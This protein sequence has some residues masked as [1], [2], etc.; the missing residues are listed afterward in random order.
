VITVFALLL[1]NI[2]EIFSFHKIL[3]ILIKTIVLIAMAV[4]FQLQ[5]QTLKSTSNMG[6]SSTRSKKISFKDETDQSLL[7]ESRLADVSERAEERKIL[8]GVIPIGHIPK[9]R[10]IADFVMLVSFI[11]YFWSNENK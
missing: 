2:N 9:P 6:S 7:N 5:Q 4:I 10:V 1:T 8:T 11:V 3:T